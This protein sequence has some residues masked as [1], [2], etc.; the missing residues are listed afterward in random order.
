MKDFFFHIEIIYNFSILLKMIES[1]TYDLKIV[2]KHTLS[3]SNSIHLF[4][5]TK[6]HCN[7]FNDNSF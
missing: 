2:Q 1:D 3:T 5:S 4:K 6:N 7:Y